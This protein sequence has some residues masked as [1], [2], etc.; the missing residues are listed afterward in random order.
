[1]IVAAAGVLLLGVHGWRRRRLQEPLVFVLAA[2]VS[3]GWLYLRNLLAYDNALIGNW[4]RASGF[5]L[6][7]E[8]TFRVVGF[9]T[10]F[11]GVFFQH[12]T[13]SIWTSWFDGMYSTMW[14]DA[15][16]VL[17]DFTNE[18][19]F[20]WMSVGLVVA[21]LPTL[22]IGLGFAC[23]TVDAARDDDAAAFLV[24]ACAWTWTALIWFALRVPVY[25][26]VK[27]FYFLGL[28]P[29]LGV[30]LARGRRLLATHAPMGR[31]ALDLSLAGVSALTVMVYARPQ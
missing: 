15:H 24:L 31:L 7:Q 23:T 29:V 3:A 2:T 10:D 19:A 22:S 14:T 13:R 26:N 18:S 28:T 11:G 12:P 17:M 5:T 4:D 8:P 6:V 27:A 30:F 21:F 20:F 25:S 1:V 9:F 16:S